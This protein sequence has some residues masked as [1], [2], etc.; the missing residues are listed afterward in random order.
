MQNLITL[1]MASKNKQKRGRQESSSS[2]EET[3]TGYAS[4]IPV[5]NLPEFIIIQPDGEKQLT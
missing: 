1:N 4:W 2:D 3:L 5:N